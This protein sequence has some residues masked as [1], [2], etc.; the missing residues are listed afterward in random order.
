MRSGAWAAWR[1]PPSWP[2]SAASGVAF[3][4]EAWDGNA[5]NYLAEVGKLTGDARDG[6]G[7]TLADAEEKLKDLGEQCAGALK[8]L[9]NLRK[10]LPPRG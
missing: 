4:K 1:T 5:A 3:H 8:E 9:K 10:S 7:E 6:M 2:A